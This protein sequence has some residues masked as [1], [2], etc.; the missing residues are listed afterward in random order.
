MQCL[1]IADSGDHMEG[2]IITVTGESDVPLIVT[3]ISTDSET[4]KP[5]NNLE[6]NS[7]ITK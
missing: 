4:S 5:G 7:T 6:L 2:I 1:P 3:M